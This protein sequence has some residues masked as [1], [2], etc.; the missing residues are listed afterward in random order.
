M[1][2]MMSSAP[3]IQAEYA[4]LTRNYAVTKK[5]YDALLARLDGLK[6][7]L[8]VKVPTAPHPS[9]PVQRLV[10]DLLFL[11]PLRHGFRVAESR[12]RADRFRTDPTLTPVDRQ[13]AVKRLRK[14]APEIAALSESYLLSLVSPS[15][16]LH[17]K[18]RGDRL[19]GRVWSRLRNQPIFDRFIWVGGILGLIA[20]IGMIF[21]KME[22]DRR[23][24]LAKYQIVTSQA[25]TQTVFLT[26]SIRD[27]FRD[28]IRKE[29][30]TISR[31]LDPKALDQVVGRLPID[32][33][34]KVGGLGLL[35][36]HGYW[37][38][39]V[40]SRFV[41]QLKEALKATDLMLTEQELDDLAPRC[42]PPPFDARPLVPRPGP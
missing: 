18:S 2:T 33:L 38:Q 19:I 6:A 1:K 21:F 11:F 9:A 23:S 41:D 12:V 24:T 29:L 15:R 40:R 20:I 17:I 22:A 30:L 4:Q 25:A 31:P 34:P 35:I 13:R 42:F 10:E 7:G 8:N 28:R 32:E 14:T 37:T 16:S 26:A 39:K 27:D 3:A 5:Q 36:V